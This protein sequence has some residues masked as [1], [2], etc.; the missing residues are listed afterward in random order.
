MINLNC[1]TDHIPYQIFKI[2]LS[3]SSEKQELVNDNPPMKIEVN[4]AENSMK[5]KIKAGRYLEI[6]ISETMKLFGSTK[7]KI[8][9]D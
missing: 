4:K 8:A 3:I 5:F 2:I 6:L 7:N 1:P 9:K